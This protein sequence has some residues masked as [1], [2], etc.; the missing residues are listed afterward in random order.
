MFPPEVEQQRTKVSDQDCH[1]FI[2]HVEN[3]NDNKADEGGGHWRGR[4]RSQVLAEGLRSI[5]VL[6]QLWGERQE[7]WEPVDNDSNNWSNNQKDLP[8]E[9]KKICSCSTTGVRKK[10]VQNTFYDT[11]KESNFVPVIPLQ[12]DD[13]IR[14]KAINREP[15]KEEFFHVT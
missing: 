11:Q 8:G 15:M 13:Q 6:G 3:H 14:Y 7:N 4:L 10:W 1:F 2:D 9:C 12:E 5:D